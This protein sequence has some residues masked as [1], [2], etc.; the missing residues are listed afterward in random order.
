LG[1]LKFKCEH[2]HSLHFECEKTTREHFSLCC[3][4]GKISL[5]ECRLFNE[6]FDLFVDENDESKHFR[7]YIRQYHSVMSFVSFGYHITLPSGYGPYCFKIHDDIY[8]RIS[9]LYPSSGQNPSYEQL[10]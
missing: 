4:N 5:L 2:Y 10:T 1:N 3:G 6:I 8:H 7:K 9:S